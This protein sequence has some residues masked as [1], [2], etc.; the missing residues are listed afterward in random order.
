MSINMFPADWKA[1]LHTRLQAFRCQFPDA[2]IYALV[3]GVFDESCYP[4]LKRAQHLQYELLF[5]GTP[6]ADEETL[7]VSPLLVEFRDAGRFTWERLLEKANGHP[8]LSL[9]VTPEPLSQLAARLA[10]WCIVDAADYTVAL[11]FADTRIL[12]Q[13][14]KILTAQQ[15]GQ[16]CGPADHWQYVTRNGDWRDLTLPGEALPAAVGISL[17]EQQCAQLMRAAEGDGILFQ[18][19]ATSPRLLEP[20]TA[21]HAHALV[22]Y[23]LD[24]ADHARLEAPP[25]RFDVCIFG[26]ENPGLQARPQLASW[27]AEPAQAQVPA[28]LFEL[29]LAEQS[30]VDVSTLS[31]ETKS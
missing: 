8:A 31:V 1:S 9:I 26:L 29:W 13:L 14:F 24:C 5:A 19:R 10:A 16:L 27:L 4:L 28:A 17:S 23:W 18:V 15:L 20:H 21:A 7:T 25:D 6:C 22:E 12:P 30:S 3:D 2:H 11:S